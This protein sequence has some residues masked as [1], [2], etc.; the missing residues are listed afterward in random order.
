[1]GIIRNPLPVKLFTGVLSSEPALFD[2]CAALIC[3]VYGPVDYE[4][5]V[6]PWDIT[7]YYRSEMGTSIFRKFIFFKE[8][9]NP[10]S[11]AA[12]KVFTNGIEERFSSGMQ[13]RV[14]LDP[15]YV[16]E[17]KVVLATTKDFSHR[18]YIGEGIYAEATLRYSTKE[19]SFKSCDH[20]YYDFRT[21]IYKNTFNAARNL[22]REELNRIRET[23]K[24]SS[25]AE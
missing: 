3:A 23:R 20:T 2:E 13:R 21:E 16:T 14:N 19:K 22:L 11:L 9:A 18:V 6:L 17:A 5:D 1:M 25:L 12:V 8:L 10:G 15:G 24:E 7:D 4:T